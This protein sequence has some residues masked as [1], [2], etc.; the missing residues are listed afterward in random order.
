[1]TVI[2]LCF[3]ASWNDFF[4]PMIMCQK[5]T[6]RTLPLMQF[7]FFGEYSNEINMAFAAALIAMIPT[8]I[9]Y[10]LA[11]KY[12]VEGMTAGAVKS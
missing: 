8:V 1:M 12:I 11:Q 5:E 10:F 4:L 3:L 7:Y 6:A 9:V 2:V